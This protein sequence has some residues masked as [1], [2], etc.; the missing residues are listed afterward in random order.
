VDPSRPDTVLVGGD[1]IR[2]FSIAPD[3][4]LE[5]PYPSSATGI[6]PRSY[7]PFTVR[8]AGA[9]HA[10][11]VRI[12]AQLPST[13]SDLTGR[14]WGDSTG[15]CVAA[16]TKV[17]CTIDVLRAGVTANI[18]VQMQLLSVGEYTVTASVMG[19]QPDPTQTNNSATHAMRIFPPAFVSAPQPATDD[20]DKGGGGGGSFTPLLLLMGVSL[21]VARE[22]LLRARHS[23]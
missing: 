4:V 20:G 10:T 1:G 16:G 17:T 22:K 5:M 18:E 11:G 2:S 12:E 7:A 14:V 19:D 13:A 15:A 23:A 8:N 6:I 3:L 21:I 9:Y